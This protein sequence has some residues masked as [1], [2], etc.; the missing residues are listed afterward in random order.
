M[1]IKTNIRAGKGGATGTGQNG[2]NSGGVNGGADNTTAETSTNN[3]VG[4]YV[5]PVNRCPG[6]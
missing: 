1:K 2:T 4:F 6:F 5:P 3:T